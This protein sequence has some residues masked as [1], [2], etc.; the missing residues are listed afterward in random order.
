VKSERLAVVSREL[1]DPKIW[2]SPERAQALGKEKK[3]LDGIVGTITELEKGLAD[4]KELFELARAEGDDDTMRA[5]KD[6][7]RPARED[8][9]RDSSSAGCS[10][11]RSTPRT[12]SSTSRRAAAARKRRTGRRC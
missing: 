2:D 9:R 4:S 12:A 6:G 11:I 1:E 7:R 8:R 5:V 10:T 3:D